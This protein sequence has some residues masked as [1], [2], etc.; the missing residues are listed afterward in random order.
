[1]VAGNIADL[2]LAIQATK[3]T[4]A[5]TA[6]HRV[7]LAGGGFGPMREA[8]DLEETTSSRLR[9]SAF[10]SGFRAE[11]TPEFYVRPKMA[12]ILLYGAM[13]AKAVSGAADPWTHTF[14]LAST[15]P[16]LTVWRTLGGLYE[17]FI[18]V[19]IAELN[20]SSASQNALRVSAR[21]LGMTSQFK[22][23][24]ETAATPE[25]VDAFLHAD[26][27]G[28]FLVEAAAVSSISN[29]RVNIATGITLA[30]GDDVDADSANEGLQVI[31]IETEQVISDYALW[32]RY[33][34]GS[35]TPADNASPIRDV[36]ELAASGVD[37]TW[38]KRTA[39]GAPVAPARSLQFTATRLQIAGISGMDA[40]TSGEPLRRTVTYRVYQPASGSGLTAVL[41][42]GQSSYAAT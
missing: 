29:I 30:Y 11:G 33:H 31:T 3:G 42:N 13:G 20:F 8:A 40:N 15:Q 6:A 4:A 14:T 38:S 2:S 7:Y 19:K 12:G 23:A 32:N 18:D 34:Y 39:A 9:N 24:A 1:M 10:I 17:R 36:V 21:L 35:T 28:Q 37:F 41:K 25:T 16:Y 22:S 27:A 26:G 5:A